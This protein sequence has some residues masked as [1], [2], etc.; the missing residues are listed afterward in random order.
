MLSGP[1]EGELIDDT[2]SLGVAQISVMGA[3]TGWQ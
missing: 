1:H 3:L 2:H